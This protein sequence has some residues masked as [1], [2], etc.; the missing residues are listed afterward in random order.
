MV[1]V[2]DLLSLF[3][4]VLMLV[5]GLSEVLEFERG[6]DKL[7]VVFDFVVLSNFLIVDFT[8]VVFPSNALYKC[9][10]D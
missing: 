8:P 4:F 9:E 10:W 5:G 7:L 6:R 3:T 2:V 1:F